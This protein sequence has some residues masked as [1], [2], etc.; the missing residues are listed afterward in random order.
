MQE[1]TTAQRLAAIDESLSDIDY[2]L[3]HIPSADQRERL[4]RRRR[5]LVLERADI[6]SSLT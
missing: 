1:P 6:K 4:M 5:E 2:A 3:Q